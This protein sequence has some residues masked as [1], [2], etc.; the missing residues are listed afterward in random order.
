MKHSKMGIPSIR[1]STLMLA[2]SMA[3]V[4]CGGGSSSGGVEDS[5][6]GST[7]PQPVTCAETEYLQE[8]ICKNKTAQRFE[9][10]EIHR[11]LKGQAYQLNLKTDQDLALSLSSESPSICDFEQGELKALDVG[12]CSLTPVS[13]THLRAHET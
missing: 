7:S 1:T 13:Y 8:G 4:G 3:M 9:P 12:K 5:N 11:F 10:L 6:N 2:I